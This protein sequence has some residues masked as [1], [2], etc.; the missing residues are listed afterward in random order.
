M[1]QLTIEAAA[2]AV[3][4]RPAESDPTA[5]I[6]R[7]EEGAVIALGKT[8]HDRHWVHVPGLGAFSFPLSAG[9]VTAMPEPTADPALVEDT[10]RRMVLPLALQAQGREVL[11]A[12]AV[13]TQAGVVALC[14]LSG[15]GKST[16][17]CALSRRGHVLWADDAV[18]FETSGAEIDALPVPF[19]LRLRPASAAFFADTAA[20]N[21]LRS[22]EHRE[23]LAAVFVLE[24]AERRAELEQLEPASAFPAVLTH[25]YC[26]SMSD[27]ERN[28]AM[29]QHY[30]ELVDRVPVF[31][32]AFP[33]GLDGLDDV[34]ELIE[35]AVE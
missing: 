31:R 21:G 26:F 32:L 15:T 29:V 2:T 9:G 27:R 17:A 18:C 14:A 5:T 20:P 11:H 7:D 1:L 22:M 10:F 24:R 3:P 13:R 34:L 19:S 25:G 16:I 35:G 23:R 4:P 6:W 33:E 12:S 30:L 8:L 28:G